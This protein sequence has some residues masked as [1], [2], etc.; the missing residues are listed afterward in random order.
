MTRLFTALPLPD[1]AADHLAGQLADRLPTTPSGL[2]LIPREQWHITVG[3]YGEDDPNQRAARL[4]E[5][6]K[7]LRAPRLSLAGSGTFSGVCWVGV[8]TGGPALGALAE[9]ADAAAGGHA[10]YTPHLTVAR[11]PKG[12]PLAEGMAR[13]LGDYRGP[14]WTAGELVLFRSELGSAGPVYTPVDQVR[15]RTTG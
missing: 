3:F 12:S 13:A 4:H 10:R 14:E 9:A 15:L 7:N 1:A 5:R 11:C 8:D 6:V 2:R